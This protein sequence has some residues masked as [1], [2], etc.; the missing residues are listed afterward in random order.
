[1]SSSKRD[2][3]REKTNRNEYYLEFRIANLVSPNPP[4][5]KGGYLGLQVEGARVIF[6]WNKGGS[7]GRIKTVPE[8]IL[9]SR[10]TTAATLEGCI[11]GHETIVAQM[12]F[13]CKSFWDLF[14]MRVQSH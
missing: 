6:G 3:F 13:D 9:I 10:L 2:L 1:M 4:F 11:S 5:D 7:I 8:G 12:F 14:N